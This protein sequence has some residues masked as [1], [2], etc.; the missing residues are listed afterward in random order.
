MVILSC[1]DTVVAARVRDIMCFDCGRV[2][3][4]GG[5]AVRDTTMLLLGIIRVVVDSVPEFR[6]FIP[7]ISEV[8]A[9]RDAM[10]VW[11]VCVSVAVR[12]LMFFVWGVVRVADVEPW[13]MFCISFAISREGTPALIALVISTNPKISNLVFIKRVVSMW[14]V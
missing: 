2:F 10:F 1:N 6:D 7:P 14:S 5:V 3:V 12:D 4:F 13:F 8:I 11:R 9:V